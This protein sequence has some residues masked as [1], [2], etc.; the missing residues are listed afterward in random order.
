MIE[1][2]VR[3]P[4]SPNIP[5]FQTAW[6]STSLGWLKTCPQLYAYNQQG[7]T[8]RQRSIHLTF[9]GL[10]AS[11]VE[12]YAKVR[13]AGSSH[14]DA[15]LA[16]VRQT[17]E[18]SG[19]RDCAPCAGKGWIVEREFAG[20]T[21][22]GAPCTACRS[23]GGAWLPWLSGDPF[24]NLYTLLRSLIWN[25]ED[26]LGSP[27]STYIRPNGHAAVELSFNFQAFEI[28][29]EAISLSGHLD[30]VVEE[31]DRRWVKD[32][33]TTKGALN[34]N[35]RQGFS[36]DNQMSLYSIAGKVILDEPVAGVLVRAAQIGVGF[37]R[38]ST[39]QVPRP[40]PVLDEWMR[41]TE[42][43]ITQARGFAINNYW[44]RNDKA[45]HMYMGCAFQKVC[46]VSPTHRQ[47]WLESDFIK[48]PPWNP[49]KARSV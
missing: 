21:T 10:Y 40:Q 27:F 42:F 45:C 16:V 34:A 23:T 41:D 39:F 18:T 12:L 26:R 32:D 13:A 8:T 44:P 29:G 11:G 49:L 3:S 47:S 22:Q 15:V 9:G 31:S 33:K 30:E 25:L 17:I 46:S 1:P 48:R 43:W 24:K 28:E 19:S 35:Y 2:P 36:P 5:N 38:F 20:G 37:T 4:F 14:D 7:W 6:D